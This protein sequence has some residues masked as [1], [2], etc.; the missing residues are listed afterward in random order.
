MRAALR[1]FPLD[2]ERRVELTGL[3]APFVSSAQRPAGAAD[4]FIYRA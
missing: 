2:G 4:L 3:R 1:Y